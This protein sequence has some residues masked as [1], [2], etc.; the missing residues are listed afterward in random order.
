MEAHCVKRVSVPG[1]RGGGKGK[2][3]QGGSRELREV[4]LVVGK[5]EAHCV[6]RVSVPEIREAEGVQQRGNRG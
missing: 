3:Q 6:E 4:L 5:V 1:S 2:G